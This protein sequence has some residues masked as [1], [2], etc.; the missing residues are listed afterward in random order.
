[1]GSGSSNATRDMNSVPPNPNAGDLIGLKWS[2][3]RREGHSYLNKAGPGAFDLAV[4]CYSHPAWE[5]RAFAVQVL[6]SLAGRDGRALAFLF[7]EC[8]NDPAWQVNEALAMAFDDYCAAV[9]YEQA[10]PVMRDWLRSDSPNV[11]RAVSE[12]LRPWTASKR[13]YFARDP[14]AAVDMLGTLKDD[15]SRYVQESVGNALRDISRKR[16]DLVVAALRAWVAEKP[17]SKP[18]RTISRYALERAVKDDLSLR[19]IYAGAGNEEVS[20]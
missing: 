3:I 15:E 11:R 5:V 10:L 12:G 20:G 16:F 14:Q 4:Q 13:A 18:R 8:G 9:G 6:G 1:M 19:Q 17:G 2:D 7:E